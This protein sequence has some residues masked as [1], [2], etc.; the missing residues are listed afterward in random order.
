MTMQQGRRAGQDRC[1]PHSHKERLLPP[2]EYI[3]GHP[4]VEVVRKQSGS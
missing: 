3:R 1:L 4:Q 2:R